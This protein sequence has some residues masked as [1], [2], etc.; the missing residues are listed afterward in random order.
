MAAASAALEGIG[1]SPTMLRR[2]AGEM[3]GAG[4]W[5]ALVL[6]AGGAAAE[7]REAAL[8]G[9]SGALLAEGRIA[10]AGVRAYLVALGVEAPALS[11]E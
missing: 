5:A 7:A 6:V 3:V 2:A 9:V 1:P 8:A 10:W 11:S 4:P